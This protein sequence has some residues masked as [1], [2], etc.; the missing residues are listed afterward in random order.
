MAADTRAFDLRQ[1][2]EIA[3]VNRETARSSSGKPDHVPNQS[4]DEAG[5]LEM[6]DEV[7]ESEPNNAAESE[8]VKPS[9][10]RKLDLVPAPADALD[11]AELWLDPALGDGLVD[12]LFHEVPIGKPKNFFR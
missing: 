6:S 8:P 11:L 3:G 2:D 1:G 5:G 4:Q 10:I 7:K 12:V 9:M